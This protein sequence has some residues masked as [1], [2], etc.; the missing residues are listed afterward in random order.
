MAA[1]NDDI[2]THGRH[3]LSGVQMKS[4]NAAVAEHSIN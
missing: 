3:E 2:F 1:D 4:V